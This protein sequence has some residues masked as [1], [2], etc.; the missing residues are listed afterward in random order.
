MWTRY[1]CSLLA[2]GLLCCSVGCSTVDGATAASKEPYE[3]ALIVELAGNARPQPQPVSS[4]H[5]REDCPTGGWVG[6][7][8]VRTRCLDCDPPYSQEETT[9]AEEVKEEPVP[10]GVPEIPIE[11]VPVSLTVA[12]DM[13]CATPAA[14][15]SQYVAAGDAGY[16][17]PIRRIV[18]RRPVRSFIQRRPIRSFFGR[19]FGRCR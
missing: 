7:G 2:A 4:K 15:G 6:D 10:F 18:A 14:T 3:N 19:I 17:G 9:D 8:T 1:L 5:K 12:K 13:A 11:T 16:R